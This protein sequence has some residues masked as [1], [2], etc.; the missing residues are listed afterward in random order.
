MEGNRVESTFLRK[1]EGRS[2][3]LYSGEDWTERGF[4]EAYERV[5]ESVSISFRPSSLYALAAD[6]S[7]A[8][9]VSVRCGPGEARKEDGAVGLLEWLF[10]KLCSSPP[11]LT[12]LPDPFESDSR[13]KLAA[14]GAA[15]VSLR[16]GMGYSNAAARAR[17]CI[18]SIRCGRG[19]LRA[20]EEMEGNAAAAALM[21][22]M[23][24]EAM[25]FLSERGVG[26]VG[27]SLSR[28]M[29][30][31]L[32]ESR[33][34]DRLAILGLRQRRSSSRRSGTYDILLSSNGLLGTKLGLLATRASTSSSLPLPIPAE[35][36]DEVS[37]GLSFSLPS[38]AF[39]SAQ[40]ARS[41]RS[42]SAP[43]RTEFSRME[44]AR[45]RT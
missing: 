15:N 32:E 13:P 25:R 34:K 19:E 18:E 14:G 38:S 33:G 9:A 36:P 5:G 2:S 22:C 20:E 30:D 26:L 37:R 3:S 12:G 1:G 42:V 7:A 40:I 29:R 10:V 17:S 24:L 16:G 39:C 45:S 23:D 21:S 27:V 8:G 6:G 44:T 41:L 4:E 43:F 28:D 31:E 35:L 11:R